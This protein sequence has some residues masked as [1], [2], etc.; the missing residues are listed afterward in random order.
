MEKQAF[1]NKKYLELCQQLGD[2]V[3]K[4]Q[5]LEDHISSIKSKI[6]TLNESFEL[7]AQFDALNKSKESVNEK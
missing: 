7:M 6:E 5:Q 2:A 3:H 1:L 4:K